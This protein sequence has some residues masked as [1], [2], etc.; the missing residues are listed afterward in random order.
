MDRCCH[1]VRA[2]D[3]S[4]LFKFETGEGIGVAPVVAGGSVYL[5]SRDGW[6]YAL[7]AQTGSLHWKSPVG[8]MVMAA[9]A[10][11]RRHV[12]CARRQ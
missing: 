4:P 8:G 2:S 5:A 12:V 1:A 9:P 6:A 3:G 11:G 10:W 7:D